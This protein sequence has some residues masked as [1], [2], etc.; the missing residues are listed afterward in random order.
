[1]KHQYSVSLYQY[2]T[3]IQTMG[4]QHCI[5]YFPDQENVLLW[6]DFAPTKKLQKAKTRANRVNPSGLLQPT[7]KPG[8]SAASRVLL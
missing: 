8:T 4:I 1:M 3:G 6:V 2:K 5:N 7:Q